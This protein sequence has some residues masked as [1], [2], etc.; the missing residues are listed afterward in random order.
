[1]PTLSPA[2]QPADLKTVHRLQ[3]GGCKQKFAKTVVL[4]SRPACEGLRP[5]FSRRKGGP[6]SKTQATSPVRT[7]LTLPLLRPSAAPRSRCPLRP[8]GCPHSPPGLLPTG[9]ATG[10]RATPQLSL[11][12]DVAQEGHREPALG[13]ADDEGAAIRGRGSGGRATS[14]LDAPGPSRPRSGDLEGDPHGPRRG[15]LPATRNA[16]LIAGPGDDHEGLGRPRGAVEE[17]FRSTA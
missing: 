8:F 7:P 10:D 12:P 14:F 17:L 2:L 3:G 15:A 13:P 4:E 16:N 5:M 9:S 1:M 11:L 6:R